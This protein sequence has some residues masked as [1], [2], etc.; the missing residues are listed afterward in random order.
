MKN[1]IFKLICLIMILPLIL[2][3]S[4]NIP[5]NFQVEVEIK[6]LDR[7]ID[8]LNAMP[9]EWDTTIRNSINELHEMAT[10][11]AEQVAEDL[12]AL[13]EES[14]MMLRESMFCG[15][16][17]LVDRCVTR[18]QDFEY[19]YR[20][21][22]YT[23]PVYEVHICGTNPSVI[24]TDT[25]EAYFSGYNF[26]NYAGVFVVNIEY[27]SGKIIM[28]NIPMLTSSD[29]NIVV[30]LFS[31]VDWTKLALDQSQSPRLTLRWKEDYSGILIR[32]T[33]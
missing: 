27:G 19:K 15:V 8:A 30:D 14:N 17:F 1:T 10:D 20:P 4:C 33:H 16:D 25:K 26:K 31:S 32:L 29:Y 7:L 5:S 23:A 24:Y 12:E 21:D 9:G 13:I 28:T 11:L 18:I 2:R 3:S 6:E 22:V